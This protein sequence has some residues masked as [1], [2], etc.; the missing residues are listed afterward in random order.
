VSEVTRITALIAARKAAAEAEAAAAAWEEPAPLGVRS[1]LPA[2]PVD[3]L[4]D[5]LADE[6]R[7]LAEFTQT[8]A[9][10][11]GTV[12]FAVLS[13]AAGGRAVVEVR[14]GWRE[15]VNVF[16][17][18][19]MPPGS[20]KSA[21]FTTMTAPLL[22][23]ERAL[24]EATS[25]RVIE[26]QT[27]RKIQSRI[28]EQQAAQVSKAKDED[29]AAAEAIAAAQMAEAIT[30][31]ALP[32]LVADDIT[33]ETC[34]S[35]L[36]EQDGRLAVLSAEGGIFATLAGRYS[37]G[38][39][40]IEVFLKGHAGDML[41]VDR[42]SRP[43]EHVDHPALTLG[44]AVQPEILRAIARMPG[45][46]GRGLLAR[47]LYAVPENNVGRR[48]I[49]TDSVPEDVR[50]TYRANVQTLVM[51]LH[52]WTDP[53][54]LT[55]TPGAAAVLVELEREIEP[56]LLGDAE[57]GH[58]ADW[59]AKLV[60]ATVRLAGLLHLADT[61]ETSWARPIDEDTVRRAVTLAR[62][63]VR[64]A[65]AVFDVMGADPLVED[66]RRV[67][68]WI[69]RYSVTAFTRRDAYQGTRPY[70]V[71]VTDMDPALRLLEVHGYIRARYVAAPRS[72]GR[73]PSPA[74]D[75]NPLVVGS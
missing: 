4:P 12:A 37:G 62:Y 71:K 6:V 32:R 19:A 53:A 35:L 36:A 14:R 73:P 75:T 13:T 52:E 65:L 45:F 56:Q 11:A 64:H 44:L 27:Q 1:E 60:G 51:A 17:V 63:F 47:I 59:A 74:W 28:A 69:E 40:S 68:R 41:R 48:R 15:P 16:V 24:V 57:L 54:V 9:D 22:D 2:F 23:G 43:P 31:P 18:V 10:L 8:P 61:V 21:V 42:K 30:V 66:A 25:P 5:W 39:P 70:F 72:A 3:A 55:L 7:A 38:V 67:L 33:S 20:R 49:G 34:A 58:V 50:A 46:R 29:G 26:A